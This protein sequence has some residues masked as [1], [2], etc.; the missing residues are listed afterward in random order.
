MVLL[1]IQISILF[2]LL[3]CSQEQMDN[4]D[5]TTAVF[6]DVTAVTVSGTVGEYTLSVTIASPD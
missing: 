1:K 4:P 3:S 2:L 6:A 5:L